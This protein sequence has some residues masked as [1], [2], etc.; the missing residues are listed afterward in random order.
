[1]TRSARSWSAG[2]AGFG[3]TNHVCSWNKTTMVH[4]HWRTFTDMLARHWITIPRNATNVHIEGTIDN[5]A[6]VYI[7][8]HQVLYAA[9]G[10]C[11]ADAIDVT[12]PAKDLD[13]QTLLAIRGHD[14]GVATYLDVTVTYDLG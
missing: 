8:G 5:D 14:T 9:S 12:V 13:P 1:M 6:T 4:T 3:T 10:N 2:Q 11:K 7:N